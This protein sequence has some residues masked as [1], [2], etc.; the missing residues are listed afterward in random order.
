M[1]AKEWIAYLQLQKHPEGGYY[2]ETYRSSDIIVPPNRFNGNR[3]ASTAIYYL[4]DKHN[5]SAFHRFNSDEI[6]HFYVGAELALYIIDEDGTL[7]KAKPGNPARHSQ[8]THLQVCIPANHWFAGEVNTS[9]DYSLIGC[10]VA[11]GF[12]FQDFELEERSCLIELFPQHKQLI[13]R[14]TLR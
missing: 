7:N 6:W 10:T 4:L 8:S 9:G 11:P 5:F 14:L 13:T 1:T 12:D 3:A 2:R